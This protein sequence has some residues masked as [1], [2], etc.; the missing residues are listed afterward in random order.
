M[1]ELKDKTVEELRKMASKKKIEGRS[2]MNKAELVRALKKKTL[3]KKTVKRRKMRGGYLTTSQLNNLLTNPQSFLLRRNTNSPPI[4]IISTF[5]GQNPNIYFELSD[6]THFS[7]SISNLQYIDP[8]AGAGGLSVIECIENDIGVYD[9]MT[10][11]QINSMLENPQGYLFN[12]DTFY[13]FPRINSARRV[14]LRGEICI[15]FTLE[16]YEG[17]YI[18]QEDRLDYKE[19]NGEDELPVIRYNP[20]FQNNLPS[21]NGVNINN[22]PSLT[23]PSGHNYINGNYNNGYSNDN[24]Y[25]GENYNGYDNGENYNNGNGNYNGNAPNAPVVS[26]LV[27]INVPTN[28]TFNEGK[29]ALCLESTIYNIDDPSKKYTNAERKV[30]LKKLSECGHVFHKECLESMPVNKR[31]CPLCRKLFRI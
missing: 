14:N 1:V 9:E 12:N 20:T 5:R 3:I 26:N 28:K 17:Q 8:S 7:C 15:I 13:P 11:E 18:C 16:G 25:Y 21:L 4:N 19:G 31:K 27:N 2:K 10:E 29:C 24:Y 30:L 22:L 23:G 6:G